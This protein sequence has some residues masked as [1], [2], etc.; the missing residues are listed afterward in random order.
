MSLIDIGGLLLLHQLL[1]VATLPARGISYLSAMTVGYF[2]N[3]NFTFQTSSQRRLGIDLLRFYGAHSL[4]GVL[5][6]GVFALTLL[7]GQWLFAGQIPEIWLSLLGVWLGG[8]VGMSLNF[9]LS[10]H[11]VFDAR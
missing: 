8:I 9:I 7:S 5:N 2:L 10:R 4:G 3:R 1:E 11:L 6:Y